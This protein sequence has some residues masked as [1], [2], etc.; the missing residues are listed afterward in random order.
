MNRFFTIAL[1]CLVTIAC[2]QSPKSRAFDKFKKQ[3]AHL[4]LPYKKS[5]SDTVSH[6]KLNI[7][8]SIFKKYAPPGASGI[9]GMLKDTDLYAVIVYSVSGD[10][11]YPIVQTY[12]AE[13]DSLNNIG[14]LEGTCCG[15]ATNCSGSYW[16]EIASDLTITQRDS[17]RIFEKD[18]SGNYLT[19]KFKLINKTAQYT[20]TNEGYIRLKTAEA[21]KAN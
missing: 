9:I 7:P 5:C 14:L 19:D 11:Q 10:I 13:G 15:S 6:L 17:E 16:G 2:N 1:L 20:I 18:K 3:I 12:N 4:K 21:T 8:D